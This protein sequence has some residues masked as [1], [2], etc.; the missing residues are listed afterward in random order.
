MRSERPPCLGDG[1]WMPDTDVV[2]HEILRFLDILPLGV[3]HA[4]NQDTQFWAHHILKVWYRLSMGPL[5]SAGVS[6]LL[7]RAARLGS[8]GS[9]V[10][11]EPDPHLTSFNPTRAEIASS[12]ME[13]QSATVKI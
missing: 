6:D 7:G 1:A 2:L 8:V 12:L 3:P 10:L 9:W 4:V 11:P 13:H 5:S